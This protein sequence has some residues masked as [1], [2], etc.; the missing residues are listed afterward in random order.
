MVHLRS[1]SQTGTRFGPSG[2]FKPNGYQICSIW[3]SQTGTRLEG[4][5][6]VWES[7]PDRAEG[8]LYVHK[9]RP[10][11]TEGPLYVRES[12]PDRAEGPLYVHKSRPDRA[13][14]PLHVQE[15]KPD[16]AEGPLYVQRTR[17]TV[18]RVLCTSWLTGL[19]VQR[20][21]R[22]APKVG[23]QY[24]YFEWPK[25][26]GAQY[27]YRVEHSTLYVY[28]DPKFQLSVKFI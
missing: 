7:W 22:S 8:P 12:W 2:Q 15:S 25:K 1:L 9:S 19:T 6:Y 10:D 23:T 5:L 20:K 28:W 3:A 18:Q 11:R 13:E 16:R 4:P 26:I 24:I 21:C 17:L 27:T 14:G